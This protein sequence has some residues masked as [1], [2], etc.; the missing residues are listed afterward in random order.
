VEGDGDEEDE[1]GGPRADGEGHSYEDAVEEDARF[2][3]EALEE[4]LFGVR[5]GLV[6]R[7]LM[8]MSG[9]SVK[10]D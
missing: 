3:E 6:L 7:V 1:E 5:E 2:E 8:L 4:E 9:A 10:R